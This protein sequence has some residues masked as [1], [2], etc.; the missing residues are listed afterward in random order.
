MLDTYIQLLPTL[1]IVGMKA[2]IVNR[3]I[4]EGMIPN[5]SYAM[6]TV[7]LEMKGVFITYRQDPYVVLREVLERMKG[8]MGINQGRSIIFA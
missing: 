4:T 6:N 8:G 5:M 1:D 2:L 3:I 7:C